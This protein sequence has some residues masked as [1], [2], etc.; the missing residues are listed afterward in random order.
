MGE[1]SIEVTK[2]DVGYYEGTGKTPTYEP[3]VRP[4]LLCGVPWTND[5]VRTYC[6]RGDDKL[7][8]FWRA[9][10]TCGERASSEEIT[11]VDLTVF[12]L[13]G[14]KLPKPGASKVQ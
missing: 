4:C 8:L 2:A 3:G 9:H 10:K 12:A 7:S 6:I 1:K 5:N 13:M 14:V 11:A